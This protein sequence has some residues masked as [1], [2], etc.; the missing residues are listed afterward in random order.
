[1]VA[2]SKR[3]RAVEV[4]GHQVE[5]GELTGCEREVNVLEGPGGGGKGRREDIVGT[6]KVLAGGGEEGEVC[7][8]VGGGGGMFPVN[9]GR[10]ISRGSGS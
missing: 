3:P 10:G 4:I 7:G 2:A 9:C 1:V 5:E 8:A 6:W